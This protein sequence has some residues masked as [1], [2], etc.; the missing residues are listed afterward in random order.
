MIKILPFY[1][2]LSL[3]TSFTLWGC[4]DDNEEEIAGEL[5]TIDESY[6]SVSA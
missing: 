3:C 6:L 5:I 2:L 1:L 4:S